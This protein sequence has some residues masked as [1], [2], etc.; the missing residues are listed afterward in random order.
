MA[1]AYA[2]ADVNKNR[3]LQHYRADSA[4]GLTGVAG[5]CLRTR[6]MS[7][8]PGE[9]PN[10]SPK[11]DRRLIY[12]IGISAIFFG[13]AILMR[14][15]FDGSSADWQ[16][17][18]TAPNQE[19]LNQM[20]NVVDRLVKDANAKVV[21]I[22]DKNGQLIVASGD[23]D[24]LDTT[25]IASLTAGPAGTR[26]IAYM[27]KRN[28]FVTQ[29]KEDQDAIHIELVGNRIILV[30]VYDPETGLPLGMMRARVRKASEEL[31]HILETMLKK[32]QEPGD[33]PLSEI[34]E[35]DIDTLFG[36]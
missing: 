26:G 32:V 27:L 22:V 33:P 1:H 16:A 14:G 25:S 28:G 19:E 9:D 11:K 34:T 3:D 31:N 2:V 7:V 23:V 8:R 6:Q 36:D 10:D 13:A 12:G 20:Q 24:N 5:L 18:T 30:I 4:E 15:M 35:K 17:S 21:F 29:F